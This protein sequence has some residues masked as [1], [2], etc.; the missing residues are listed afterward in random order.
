MSA[1]V[2]AVIV[3]SSL[4]IAGAAA[5]NLALE[6]RTSAAWRHMV[7]TLAVSG[8]LLMPALTMALPSWVVPIRVTAESLRAGLPIPDGPEGFVAI[9][10]APARLSATTVSGNAPVNTARSGS[11]SALRSWTAVALAVYVIGVLV[12]V[13][14]L[15]VERLALR[16][17]ARSAA[18]VTDPEWLALLH[19]SERDMGVTRP[20]RLLRS[21]ERSMPMAFGTR[22]PTIVIPSIADTWTG[23][24]RRAVLLHELAHVARRD[25]LTQ[26]LAAVTCAVYWVHPGTWWVARRLRIER[27]LACDDRVLSIGTQARD[28][29]AHL[30]DLAYTLGGYRAPALV[31][32]MARPRQIEG[33]MLAVLDAA[34]HRAT[35]AWRSRMAGLVVA[36]A[37]VVPLAAAETMLVPDATLVV[38]EHGAKPSIDLVPNAPLQQRATRRQVQLPGTWEIRPS[39]DATQVQLQLHERVNSSHGFTIAI[40]QLEG[41]SPAL[42][43]GSGGATQF[44]IRR[45]AGTINFEGTVRSGVG[46]G[47]Y[48]FTPSTTFPAELA[49]RGF[50]RPSADDQYRLAVGNIGTAFLDELNAQKYAQTDLDGLVKSADHGVSLDYLREM[51]R[52]GYRLGQLESLIRMRDHGVTPDYVHAMTSRGLPAMSADEIVRVRDHG[53]DPEYVDALKSYGYG[54]LSIDGLVNARDHGIDPGYLNGMRNAGFQLTL[55]ELIRARDHGVDPEYVTEMGALGFKRLDVVELINAR[56]HGVDPEYAKGLRDL[57]YALTLVELRNTRD[58]G[59]DFE[60][61]RALNGLGYK[62]LSAAELIRLR[63]HGVAPDFIRRQNARSSRRLSIDELVRI[64]ERAGN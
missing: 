24:R 11:G 55:P 28:Y 41:F 49:K 31:V 47:T 19:E 36:A 4:V 13:S 6:R 52:I 46:A 8:L 50:A 44:S 3:K 2:I 64:R 15:F 22:R 53:V 21:L 58:H 27:E 51:G 39:K 57:G 23:D 35:P 29:A 60:Y 56:D 42:F 38:A 9:D 14:R 40:D 20:V 63:D 54:S 45:E 26:L 17:M 12:L 1:L 48:T 16:R 62:G 61:V 25:C 33:R 34:R 30:L 18:G 43:T 37:V 5:V 59:V 10:P 32:S 7:W